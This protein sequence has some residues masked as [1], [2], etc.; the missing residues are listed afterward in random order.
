MNRP[1]SNF[2]NPVPVGNPNGFGSEHAPTPWSNTPPNWPSPEYAD[3]RFIVEEESSFNPLQIFLYVVRYRWL[4][5]V[6]LLT[7]IVAGFLI[8]MV[9]VPKYKADAMIEV[10]AP[11]ARIIEDL[12][13][14]N[15]SNNAIAFRTALEKLKSRE[16]I[17][18]VVGELRLT[19]KQQFLFPNSGFSVRSLINRALG[20]GGKSFK[21]LKA[22]ERERRAIRLVREGLNIKLLFGTS[23][24]SINYSSPSKELARKI[25]NQFANSYIA[26]KLDQTSET[27]KL[28]RQFIGEQVSE[29]KKRLEKAE[30]ELVLYA[31]ANGINFDD[32]DGSLTSA[33]IKSINEAMS[34][35]IQ[36]RLKLERL[37]AQ[38]KA[39]KSLSLEDVIKNEGIQQTRLKL[40]EL[41]AEYSQKLSTFKPSYPEMRELAAQ[42]KQLKFLM[43]TDIKA[44]A[45][46]VIQKHRI[47][48]LRET[49]LRTKMRE[50]EANQ[51]VYQEKNIKY[52]ILK[53]EVD[54]FRSQYKSLID[55][56]NQLGVA[57]E[58]KNK[59]ATIIQYAVTPDRPFSPRLSL[60][61]AVALV[62]SM[63]LAAAVVYLLE[64][65]N[66]TFSNPDQ[67][68]S[69]LKL[70]VLGILPKLSEEEFQE[71][72]RDH[73]SS[74]AEAFRTL[75]TALQFTGISGAPKSLMIT[76]TEPS[77]GKSTISQKLAEN[78]GQLGMKVL[79]VDSDMRRPTQHRIAGIPNSLGLSN[80]LTNTVHV[81][82]VDSEVEV[83]RNTPWENVWLVTAGTPPPNPADLLSSQKMGLF[84]E[85]CTS[86]FDIVIIDSP[87]VIG[88][89][90]A[91]LLS[92]LA[93]ATM[94]VV[95]A[96]K[97]TRKAVQSALKRLRT[98]AGHIV[99][100]TLNRFEMDNIEYK[101]SY[102]YMNTNYLNDGAEQDQR[103]HPSNQ[104]EVI[105]RREDQSRGSTAET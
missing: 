58:I 11:S 87:P 105:A 68:E 102:N 31:K 46:S 45:D 94:L 19:E 20:R 9:M 28:A 15:Q 79:I 5:G 32:K 2:N 47:A 63:I 23:I 98:A 83:M 86:R 76:S 66:N 40:S 22:D 74:L 75:R 44:I 78:F 52:T 25:A 103:N 61:L 37:V 88:L 70:P 91:L 53:R 71:Q 100:T 30:K 41:Q 57:S 27:S 16:M 1:D 42:I 64:L 10:Q 14:V 43:N 38:I 89:A 90:D 33:N 54:S 81:S 51:A 65:L 84:I 17:Q 95:S 80:V 12:Q 93:E 99:G 56:L 50:L 67:L 24:I 97:P 39:G 36:E 7:G 104:P 6:L 8:T 101:Y 59:S 4:I 29:V 49:D 26:S 72:I 69:E 18:R 82:Q 13:V 73:R 3:P 48:Q 85:A 77:E 96:K 62:V 21:E 34:K 92:R 35:A 55:K 60:N